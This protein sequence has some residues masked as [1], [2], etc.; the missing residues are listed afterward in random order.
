MFRDTSTSDVVEDSWVT[1]CWISREQLA[2]VTL[3]QA[4]SAVSSKFPK[5]DFDSFFCMSAFVVAPSSA[6]VGRREDAK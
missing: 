4:R 6:W 2:S 1:S 3:V 5:S